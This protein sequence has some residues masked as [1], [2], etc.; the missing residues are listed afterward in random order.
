MIPCPVK[1][2][3]SAYQPRSHLVCV[4]ERERERE[5]EGEFGAVCNALY[6]CEVYTFFLHGPQLQQPE[7]PRSRSARSPAAWAHPRAT[8]PGGMHIFTMAI[9]QA[10]LTA[11]HGRQ[12]I[13]LAFT[14]FGRASKVVSNTLPESSPE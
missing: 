2:A 5:S 3:R 14:Q 6:I 11:G 12:S 1:V 4:C 10:H 13:S 8:G 9:A 7:H